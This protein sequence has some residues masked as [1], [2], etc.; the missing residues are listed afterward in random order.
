MG[1]KVNG[2][3][4]AKNGWPI[5]K[6]I[7]MERDR[8]E[9]EE[10]KSKRHNN[11]N[12]RLYERTKVLESLLDDLIDRVATSIIN[13]ATIEKKIDAL[14]ASVDENTRRIKRIADYVETKT[15]TSYI[16]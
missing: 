16:S 15:D 5:F 10:E 2:V 12:S 1:N 9:L 11:N 6:E 3:Y 8:K 4:L 7:Q 14:Q 13:Q